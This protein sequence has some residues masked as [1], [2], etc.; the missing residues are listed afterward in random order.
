METGF[1]E[2][3]SL[4][5]SHPLMPSLCSWS[6]QGLQ[7]ALAVIYPIGVGASKSWFILSP[8]GLLSVFLPFSYI[9]LKVFWTV[10]FPGKRS[11]RV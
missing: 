1:G 6:T 11:C 9:Y 8:P 3:L 2:P 7:S 4:Q 5:L 10:L